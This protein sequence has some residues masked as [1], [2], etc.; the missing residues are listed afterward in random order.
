MH[1]FVYLIR[2]CELNIYCSKTYIH[3]REFKL[4]LLEHNQ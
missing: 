1:L 4:L 3:N 2:T